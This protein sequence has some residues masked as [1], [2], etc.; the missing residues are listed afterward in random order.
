MSILPITN[1]I[2]QNSGRPNNRTP[3]NIYTVNL[4]VSGIMLG[5]FCVPPNMV[6]ILYGGNWHFGEFACKL[7]PAVQGKAKI[8]F[9]MDTTIEKCIVF[10]GQIY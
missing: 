5:L 8:L 9:F 4:A 3:R 7:V 10:Q 2:F 1:L 6:Q